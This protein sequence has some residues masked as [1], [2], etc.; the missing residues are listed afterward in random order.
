M[1][2]KLVFGNQF[3]TKVYKFRCI[4]KGYT[5]PSLNEVCCVNNEFLKEIE[6]ERNPLDNVNE[7]DDNWYAFI[8]S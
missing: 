6:I 3:Q 1:E 4:I 5:K 7:L 8:L 2:S